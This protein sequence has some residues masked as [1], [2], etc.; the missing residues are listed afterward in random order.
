LLF[1]NN[2]GFGVHS[3]YLARSFDTARKQVLLLR[4]HSG[5]AYGTSV[6]RATLAAFLCYMQSQLW[7]LW[8]AGANYISQKGT[9]FAKIRI[10]TPAAPLRH[11]YQSGFFSTLPK[12]LHLNADL[13][14]WFS[15]PKPRLILPP[16]GGKLRSYS[17]YHLKNHQAA[18]AGMGSAHE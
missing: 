1:I 11:A 5:H 14:R 18:S 2:G 8:I 3:P 4:Q 17:I 15:S 13:L 7:Q 12:S 10:T 6:L 16:I 9:I